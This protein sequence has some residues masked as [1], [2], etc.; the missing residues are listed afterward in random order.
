V[1]ADALLPHHHRADVG[2]GGIFDEMIDRIAAEDLDSL[3]L[4]DFR[5]RGA[6]LHAGHFVQ[7]W[8]CGVERFP[9]RVRLLGLLRRFLEPF[10]WRRACRCR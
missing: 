7:T 1:D 5:N 9:R 6:E 10:P 8:C 4:H 3:A 2:I